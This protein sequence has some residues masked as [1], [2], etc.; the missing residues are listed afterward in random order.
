MNPIKAL[1]YAFWNWRAARLSN[2]IEAAHALNDKSASYQ[3]WVKKQEMKRDKVLSML[4][5]NY[6]PRVLKAAA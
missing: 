1:W 4:K 2:T 6:K 5:S 3:N